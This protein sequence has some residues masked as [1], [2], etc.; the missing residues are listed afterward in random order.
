[1]HVFDWNDPARETTEEGIT[2]ILLDV[3]DTS[4]WGELFYEVYSIVQLG[5]S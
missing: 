5:I 4:A 1:M 2:I 3:Y